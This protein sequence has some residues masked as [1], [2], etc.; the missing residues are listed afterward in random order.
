MTR[1]VFA[2][3]FALG[4]VVS[5]GADQIIPVS[6]GMS[7]KYNMTQEAGEG[8]KLSN[9]KPDPDGKIRASV[10]YRLN[11]TKNLDGKQ[12]LEFEMHRAGTVTNI[13]LLTVNEH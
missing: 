6:E 4:P 10:T 1:K 7:W 2:L 12:L 3:L 13:D 11:G 9:P 5:E 8:F